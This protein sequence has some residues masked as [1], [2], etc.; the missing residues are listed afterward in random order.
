MFN[1]NQQQSCYPVAIVVAL[2][3]S[4]TVVMASLTGAVFGMHSFL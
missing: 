1:R 2:A 4:V 3:L